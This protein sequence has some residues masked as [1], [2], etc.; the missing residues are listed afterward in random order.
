[1]GQY[2]SIKKALNRLKSQTH[3]GQYIGNDMFLGY[4]TIWDEIT[5][6]SEKRLFL[7]HSN[8]MSSR[9]RVKV[10]EI[11]ETGVRNA[12]KELEIQLLLDS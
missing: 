4:M 1:M 3:Q 7:Y 8:R 2:P 12:I 11:S 10:S 5:N 9:D 6:K